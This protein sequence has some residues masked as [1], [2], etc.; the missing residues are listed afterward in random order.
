M[1]LPENIN[2]ILD[3]H[4]ARGEP[5]PDQYRHP[6]VMP[7]AQFYLSAFWALQ[8]DRHLGFGGGGGI[9]FSAIDRYA[10]RLGR[11]LHY[12]LVAQSFADPRS[13][14]PNVAGIRE[15]TAWY[16]SEIEQFVRE[17]PSQ[18]W[19]LHRRWKDHRT[20]KKRRAA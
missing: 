15:L 6:E 19:W 8:H 1:S 7:E 14:A 4:E 17:E 11:P 9:P 16:T 18:Y 13:C 5:I 2:A 20:T 10:R 3:G 12:E